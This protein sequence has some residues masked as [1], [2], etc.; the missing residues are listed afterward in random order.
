MDAAIALVN[1]AAS[2]LIAI[3]LILAVLSHR[4]HDGV[5][6]KIGLICMVVGF[7]SIAM[8]MFDGLRETDAVGF[9]KPIALI[10]AGVVVVIIGY[11]WRKARAGR[12]MRRASDWTS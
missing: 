9:A 8:R 3:A 10:N 5:V 7:G 12:P 4:I 2:G 11:L 1:G 6:I